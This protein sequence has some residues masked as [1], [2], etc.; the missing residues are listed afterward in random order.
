MKQHGEQE[1]GEQLLKAARDNIN[2]REV[3]TETML[4]VL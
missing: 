4:L 2:N 3:I 1:E